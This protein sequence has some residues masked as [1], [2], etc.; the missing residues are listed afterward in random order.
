MADLFL[1]Y[2]RVETEFVRLLHDA[3]VREGKEAWVDWRDIPPS[4]D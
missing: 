4:F 2:A 3:L 1:S